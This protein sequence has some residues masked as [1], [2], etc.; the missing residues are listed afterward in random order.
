[1]EGEKCMKPSISNSPGIGKKIKITTT[2]YDLIVAV[3]EEVKG[4]EEAL[5]VPAVLDLVKRSQAKLS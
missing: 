3:C 4:E 1:M 5:I 2:I